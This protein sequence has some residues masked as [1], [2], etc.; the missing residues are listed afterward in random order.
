MAWEHGSD[1]G[2]ITGPIVI[3]Y[4]HLTNKWLQI[5]G[6][7]S[8]QLKVPRNDLKQCTVAGCFGALSRG[9]FPWEGELP[10]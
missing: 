6:I 7:M 1:L 9:L 3:V 2:G 8:M 10:L 4:A 5:I